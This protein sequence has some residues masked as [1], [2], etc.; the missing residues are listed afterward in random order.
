M[1]HWRVTC[2]GWIQESDGAPMRTSV[3]F[4]RQQGDQGGHMMTNLSLSGS[5]CH[6]DWALIHTVSWS[7]RDRNSD[8]G[9]FISFFF[10]VSHW[11]S[12][13]CI[14]FFLLFSF[15]LSSVFSSYVNYS[16]FSHT[17]TC[18]SSSTGAV[19][20]VMRLVSAEVSERSDRVWHVNDKDKQP[21]RMKLK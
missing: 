10:K 21:Q 14:L 20:R 2:G 17:Y 5:C 15:L 19:C 6:G 13:L 1:N 3:S 8:S 12:S 18:Q 9:F 4:P 16:V 11:V 7:S